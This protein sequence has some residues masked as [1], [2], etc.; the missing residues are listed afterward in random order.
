M[1]TRKKALERRRR[2]PY[3]EYRVA[4]AKPFPLRIDSTTIERLDRLA[5]LMSERAAG[6]PVTRAGVIRVALE[7]GLES[8]EK[9]LGTAKPKRKR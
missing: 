4:S 2:P 7:R 8:L 9:E 6:A 1:R 3:T 5:S